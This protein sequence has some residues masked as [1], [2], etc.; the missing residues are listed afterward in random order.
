ML[1]Y[2]EKHVLFRKYILLQIGLTDFYMNI[3]SPGVEALTYIECP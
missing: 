1:V 2:G 3:T